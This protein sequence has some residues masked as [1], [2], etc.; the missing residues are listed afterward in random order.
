MINADDPAIKALLTAWHEAGRA[1]FEAQFK[2]LDYDSREY[3]KTA[4]QGR[5]YINLDDGTSGAFMVD[6]AT[7]VVYNI[8]AYGVPHKRLVAGTVATVTGAML[9]AR[10]WARLRA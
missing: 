9:D 6:R 1:A 10:R 8:K 3:I 7:G 4:K 2:S 5:K